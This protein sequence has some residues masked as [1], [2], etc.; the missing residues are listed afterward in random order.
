MTWS[1]WVLSLACLFTLSEARAAA[2]LSLKEAFAAALKQSESLASQGESV[3]QAEERFHGALGSVLPAV[4]AS[5]QWFQQDP[6]GL[7]S[8]SAVPQQAWQTTYKA[9]ATM[10]LFR[11]FREYAALAAAGDLVVSEKEAYEWAGGQLYRDTAQAFYLVL[12]LEKDV[13]TQRSEMAFY[14]R[15]ISTL[16]ERARI[17]RSRKTE[18]LTARSA[19]AILKA[20]WESSLA[21][22]ATARE[23]LAFLTGLPPETP[24]RDPSGLP[25][26]GSLESYLSAVASRPDVKAAE[27]NLKAARAG[28][29][30]ARGAHLPSADLTGNYYLERPGQ[31]RDVKWDAMISVTLPLF[32]GGTV[33]SQTRQAQSAERQAELA[34]SR[35][36]R[37]AAEELRVAWGDVRFDLSQVGAQQEAFELSRLNYE[38]EARDY[39]L[40]LVNN[41]EVLQAQNAYQESQRA[42]DRAQYA[43]KTDFA[44]LQSL[45]A[46]VM[47]G[48]S[49]QIS[50]SK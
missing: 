43:A 9:T 32:L 39:N 12:F 35:L 11:G 21:Q 47:P 23:L 20:Q 42:R 24:Y 50:G 27:A 3:I 33:L 41:V 5:G 34:L 38:A 10:A 30:L 4:S 48:A 6:T 14:D 22:L 46:R 26:L 16:S 31:L 36:K 17:G 18:V 8:T 44:R 28:V 37:Q 29:N 25:V 45:A 15:R 40:G 7:P 1:K 49:R 13:E 19:R 2:G